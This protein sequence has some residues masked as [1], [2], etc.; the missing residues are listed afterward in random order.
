MV[1]PKAKAMAQVR[2]KPVTREM[3]VQAL[4]MAA[5]E[6]MERSFGCS[7]CAEVSGMKGLSV[8]RI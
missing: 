2:M 6:V 7:A 5:E 1:E 3:M 4:M 8:L